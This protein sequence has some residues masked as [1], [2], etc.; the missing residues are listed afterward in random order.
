MNKFL[1]YLLLVQVIG[2][3]NAVGQVNIPTSATA[4]VSATPK[5]LPAAYYA[6]PVNY[7]R[8]YSAVK[9]T[10]DT[11]QVNLAAPPEDIITGT[12]YKDS[13]GRT[14]QTVMHKPLLQKM[15]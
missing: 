4:P 13:Y 6:N 9:P 5:K 8:T 7:V 1:W 11:G 3:G 14:L 15:I 2:T 12:S 10:T